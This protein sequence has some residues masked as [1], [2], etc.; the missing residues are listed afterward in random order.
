MDSMK[1][2]ELK[3]PGG[4]DAESQLLGCIGHE[5]GDQDVV[6]GV[7][8]TFDIHPADVHLFVGRNRCRGRMWDHLE[9]FKTH[10]K[11][12]RGGS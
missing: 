3:W 4:T 11:I 7:R 8:K 9:S 10:Q 1:R 6:F 12:Q 5:D 2:M